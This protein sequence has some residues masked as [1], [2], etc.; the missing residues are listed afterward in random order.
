MRKPLLVCICGLAP[1][2]LLPG[3]ALAD[4]MSLGLSGEVVQNATTQITYAVSAEGQGFVTVT[5]NA[6]DVACGSTPEDD[7]G[8]AILQPELLSAPQSGMFSGSVN[9]TPLEAGAFI[10]CGWVAGYGEYENDRGGPTFAAASLPIGVARPTADAPPAPAKRRST[11]RGAGGARACGTEKLD[12]VITATIK[13]RGISC[14]RAHGVVHAVELTARDVPVSP[15]FIYSRSYGVSTPAGHF[16]CRREPFG[17]AGTEH[18]IRCKRGRV[19]VSWYTT[20]D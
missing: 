15:Y 2:A 8:I 12:D 11:G 13:A 14:G 4:T 6:A 16:E 9:F 7:D 18:N 20:Y 3:A 5:L 10:V 17:L 19:R 1:A